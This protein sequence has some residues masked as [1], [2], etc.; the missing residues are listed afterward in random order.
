M[1]MLE[2]LQK[3]PIWPEIVTIV[4]QSGKPSPAIQQELRGIG[5]K[6]KASR[7]VSLRQRLRKAGH[8]VYSGGAPEGDIA[9]RIKKD[10]GE[11]I[12]QDFEKHPGIHPVERASALI[13]HLSEVRLS[14]LTGFARNTV[15]SRLA[16]PR[17]Y[18]PSAGSAFGESAR[19]AI[20]LA[21]KKGTPD[22]TLLARLKETTGRDWNIDML[23][24]ETRKK[25]SAYYNPDFSI[26]NLRAVQERKQ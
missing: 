6:V 19:A 14:Q 10:F 7:V 12:A 15:R 23:V 17:K 8:K 26:E 5:Y 21:L 25:S 9:K 13:P 20:S 24:R 18:I 22:K 16:M 1:A 3:R 2:R 4:S 11:R